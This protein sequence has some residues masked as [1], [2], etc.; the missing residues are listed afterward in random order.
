[1]GGQLIQDDHDGMARALSLAA[2]VP[3]TS[4]NPRVGAVVVRAGEVLAEAA[5]EGPGHPHAEAAV[6]EG[7]DARGATVYVTL[8]P[9][10]HFG[11]TPPCVPALV[12]AGVSRVVAAIEDPDPRV[13]GRG[14]EQLRAEGVDVA[15]GALAAEAAELNAAYFHHRTTGRTYLR[16]KLALTLDGRLGARDRSSKWITGPETRARVHLARARADAVMV[17]A[18]TVAADDPQL[19]ARLPTGVRRPARVIVDSSG[20]TPRE[21][22]LFNPGGEVVVATTARCPHET[23]TSWKERGAEVLIVPEGPGG[24]DLGALLATLSARGWLEILCEGGARLATSLLAGGLVD[25]LELHLGPMVTGNGGPE[26]GDLGITSL[27]SA[28]RWRMH[29]VERSGDDVLLTLLPREAA[30]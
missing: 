16:L 7:I 24:V 6:L 30:G 23:Q 1:M 21:A 14:L 15:V 26:I 9:C 28:P 22:R 29:S 18:G 17:G 19:T 2:S 27:A 5:H 20:R 12:E 25:R 8:E 11:R 4:P 3:F 10:V 13:R